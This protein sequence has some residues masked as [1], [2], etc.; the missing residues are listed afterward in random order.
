MKL[1]PESASAP[2]GAH[3]VPELTRMKHCMLDTRIILLLINSK[4]MTRSGKVYED[5][6]E[7]ITLFEAILAENW[8]KADQLITGPYAT[9][10]SEFY[11]D[12]TQI[13][14]LI[15]TVSMLGVVTPDSVRFAKLLDMSVK[16]IEATNDTRVLRD[17]GSCFGQTPM[18][19]SLD[20]MRDPLNP[21]CG[22]A[23]TTL[24]AKMYEKFM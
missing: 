22:E 17:L 8:E 4:M 1:Y 6:P 3:T 12:K 20:G 13:S 21:M 23:Y 14:P 16:M 11:D 18:S 24:C 19:I 7:Q 9:Y 5:V 15:Y 10:F 2:L